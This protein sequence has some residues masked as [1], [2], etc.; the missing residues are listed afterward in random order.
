M[1]SERAAE[2]VTAVPGQPEVAASGPDFT[3]GFLRTRRNLKWRLYEDHVLPAWIAEMDLAVADPVRQALERICAE[4]DCGYPLR[5]GEIADRAVARAFARRM[6]RRHGWFVAPEAVQ[7]CTELVQASLAAIM[8]YS[9]PGDG[10]IIQTPAYPPFYDSI[11]ST[12][13]IVAANPLQ[14]GAA[15]AE[16]DCAGLDRLAS[17]GSAKILLFCNPHNPTG[18]AFRHEELEEVGRIA[19]RHDL[20][21]VSDE[22][23]ADLVYPGHGHVPIATVHPDVAA[24]TVTLTSAS[25]SFNIAGLRCGVMHFGSPGLQERFSQRIPPKLLGVPGIAG[26]DA[27]IAAWDESQGWLDQCLVFLQARRDQLIR[28]LAEELCEVRVLMPE[29]TYLAWLDFSALALPD[30]PYRFFLD[31]AAVALSDGAN[32]GDAY[33]RFARF[34]FATSE[35]ILD[36]VIDRMV[37]AVRGHGSPH[38][39][40]AA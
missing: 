6:A 29:A 13:R 7:L 18:R 11:A 26:I 30:T 21:I 23:H 28:R 22:I 40:I 27:T 15:G 31:R 4:H 32:F 1:L 12:G 38:Q 14:A 8:A 17:A 39:G 3:V 25:K 24:R 16:I 5:D 9:D 37:A 19:V 2:S 20:V 10:I 34:N 36:A 35:T 33:S